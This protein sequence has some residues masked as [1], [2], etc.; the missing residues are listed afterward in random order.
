MINLKKIRESISQLEGTD[1][2]ELR[3]V[4]VN[5][6]LLSL[7]QPVFFDELFFIIEDIKRSN[8]QGCVIEAGVWSGATAIYIK[9]LMNFFEI[10]RN[11]WLL[12]GFGQELDFSFF[13][14]EKDIIAIKKF[15]SWEDVKTPS[16]EDVINN[17][18]IFDLWDEKIEIIQGDIFNTYNLCFED[19]IAL[20]RVDLDFYESTYFILE[21][22]YERVSIGGYVVIDDYGVNEFNCKEAVDKFRS[23]NNILTELKRVGDFVAYWRKEN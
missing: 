17:F 15:I 6:K 11:L 5:S 20:L 21:K 18:K 2:G 19:S 10:N 8:I 9:A 13:K 14:H 23:E 12:D 22:F 1:E 7:T 4:L 3:N 16:K